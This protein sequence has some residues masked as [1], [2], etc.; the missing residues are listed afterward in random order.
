MIDL[1]MPDQKQN[2]LSNSLVD[3]I[4]SSEMDAFNDLSNWISIYTGLHFPPGKHLN[5]YRRLLNLCQKLEINDL[6]EMLQHLRLK[7]MP[8]LPAEL[9]RGISTNHSFFFRET[10]VLEYFKEKIVPTLPD[11]T[12]WRIWSAA[13]S[14]GEEAYTLAIILSELLGISRA[15]EKSAILGTDIS[16]SMIAHAERGIYHKQKL[17]MVNEMVLKRYFRQVDNNQWSINSLIQPMCTFRRL[18]LNSTPW[19]FQNHFHVI[20]C[21]NVLYY[22]DRPMQQ[23]LIE[24]M[25]DNALPGG[26]LVTSVT[27]TLYWAKTRWRPI[28]IGVYRKV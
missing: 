27:E 16:Y 5:L 26:W 22:F 20:F 12:R 11:D 7:D 4:P 3:K 8:D 9:A 21:R 19:P 24:R 15:I 28:T 23:E 14:S 10:E 17:E 2:V 18:N 25:Y 6:N 1:T 13:A